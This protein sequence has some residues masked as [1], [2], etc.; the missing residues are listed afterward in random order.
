MFPFM[1]RCDHDE[2]VEELRSEI[3]DLKA[4]LS[5]LRDP[6]TVPVLADEPMTQEKSDEFERRRMEVK[7]QLRSLARTRPSQVGRAMQRR[8][9]QDTAEKTRQAYGHPASAMFAAARESVK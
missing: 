6:Q 5:R 9:A 2:L 7:Q 4:E 1:L 3:L 8:I